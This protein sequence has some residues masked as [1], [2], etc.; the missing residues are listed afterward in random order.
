[1]NNKVGHGTYGER[2]SAYTAMV[3]KPGGRIS[4]GMAGLTGRII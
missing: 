2:R 1:M 4:S 3:E